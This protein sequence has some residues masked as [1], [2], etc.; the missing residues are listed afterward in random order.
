MRVSSARSHLP[1]VVAAEEGHDARIAAGGEKDGQRR[2]GAEQEGLGQLTQRVGDKAEAAG[3]EV[4]QQGRQLH[5]Q[6]IQ[7]LLQPH[8]HSRRARGTEGVEPHLQLLQQQRQSRQLL[9]QRGQQVHGLTQK[10]LQKEPHQPCQAQQQR[11]GQHGSGEGAFEAHFPAAEVDG[12]LCQRGEAQRNEEGQQP[13]QQ[14]PHRQIK[15]GQPHGDIGRADEERFL[16]LVHGRPP[17][18]KLRLYFSTARGTIE[19]QM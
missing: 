4:L 8:A 12:R 16:L 2:G 11:Q 13:Q 14:I 3:G 1:S 7:Q 18:W 6:R 15:K 19:V 5:R 10:L 17:F 9:G